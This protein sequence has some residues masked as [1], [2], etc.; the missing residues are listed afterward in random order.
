MEIKSIN[1][2]QRKIKMPVYFLVFFDE[3]IHNISRIAINKTGTKI[4]ITTEVPPRHLAEEQLEGY[5]NKDIN[6]FLKPYAKDVREYRFPNKLEYEGIE[7]MPK[8]YEGFFKNTPDLHCKIMN[9][10]VYK[11]KVIDYEIV[12]TKGTEFKAISIFE[13]KKRKNYFCNFYV[14][15]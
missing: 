9:R 5:N 2:I 1:F 15:L 10:I 8:R 13:V 14:K 11:N 6:A 7:N 3:N 12:T 4:A